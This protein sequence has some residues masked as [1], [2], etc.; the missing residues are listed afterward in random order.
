MS[1]PVVTVNQGKLR[2]RIDKDFD[3]NAYYTFLG[4]P[5]AKPPV[6]SRRFK[7]PQP[8]ESWQGVRDATKDGNICYQGNLINKTVIGSEDCLYLNVSTRHLP[9]EGLPA[10]PVLVHFHGGAFTVGSGNQED[11]YFGTPQYLMTQDVVFVGVNYRLAILGFLSLEDESLEVP[12][13]AGLKDQVQ[14][15]RWVQQNITSFNGDANNVTIFGISAG[16]A[17]VQFHI[18]SPLSKGLFHKAISQSG[19]VLNPWAWGFKNAIEVAEKLGESVSTEKEALEVLMKTSVEKLYDAV[20]AFSDDL[21]DTSLRRPFSP[22]IEK[23]NPTAFLSQHP[24]EILKSGQ[25]NQVPMI[26]G[27]TS[28]EGWRFDVLKKSRS[29][30]EQGIPWFFNLKSGTKDYQ[31]VLKS[32][33]DIYGGCYSQDGFIYK[34]YSDAIFVA[35]ITEFIKLVVGSSKNPVFCYQF[36]VERPFADVL[37]KMV[38]LKAELGRG[39]SHGSDIPY[40][41]MSKGNAA[42]E[43]ADIKIMRNIVEMWTNFAR[44][45][46]PTIDDSPA[47]WEAAKDPHKFKCL[48]ID[49]ELTLIDNPFS[50]TSELWGKL[51]EEYYPKI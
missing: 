50:Q 23:P 51:F 27:C 46:R 4:I 28:E 33:Q 6:G 29:R 5:F 1:E 10:K 39:A 30:I 32:F 42:H 25:F 7:A 22:V 20:N 24:I 12:G 41:F 31:R 45:G 37:G 19:S 16:G 3:G 21:V 13:N 38:N 8:P 44:H 49:E 48:K 47:N 18:I 43:P 26:V 2:G 15:L 34:L 35:G 36:A 17:S 9:S 40:I 14:A 11:E